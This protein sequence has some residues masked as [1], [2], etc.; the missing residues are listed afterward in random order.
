MNIIQNY[1]NY[2]VLILVYKACEF[3]DFITIIIYLV[4]F[5]I[6]MIFIFSIG[7]LKQYMHDKKEILLVLIV[8]FLIGC[9]GG[10]FF[11]EPI[12]QELPN[13]TSAVESNLPNSQ[14]T[15]Y[16]DLSSSIDSNGLKEELSS[17]K[18]FISYNET[19]ISIPMWNFNEYEREYFNEIVG[20]I[21]SNY[22]SYNITSSGQ[23]DIVL[24]DNYSATSAIKSFSD[25]YKLVYGGTITY[26]Q[27]HSKLVIE[28]SALDDF[29]QVLLSK[30]I[31]PSKMEGAIQD[32]VNNTNAS[33]LSNMEFV[34]VCGGIGVVVA[35]I[36]IYFDSVVPAYRRFKKFMSEK[37]KR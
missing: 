14:E 30:G 33:M 12:Y 27:I 24:A 16:L 5:I 28:S 20:N 4:L 25:W 17:T 9:I 26:A 18:G 35:I 23:I 3:M 37:R 6:M 7:M 29:Q 32:S 1:F 11:L 10:A 36:G 15:L 31:V 8:A 34:A 22:K 21:D 2:Y 19:S 13:V